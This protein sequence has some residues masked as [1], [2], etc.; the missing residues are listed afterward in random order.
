MQ[1]AGEFGPPGLCIYL[2]PTGVKLQEPRR[3]WW[4]RA[5][6]RRQYQA[7]WIDGQALI[8]EGILLSGVCWGPG[9]VAGI[10]GWWVGRG[11]R[12]WV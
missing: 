9:W 3:H 10:G 6:R 7:V 4:A 8:G 5:Q 12:S 2:R 1:V 11:S